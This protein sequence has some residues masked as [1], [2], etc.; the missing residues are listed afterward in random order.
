MEGLG[1]FRYIANGRISPIVIFN[2]DYTG[3]LRIIH[4]SFPA[5]N[6]VKLNIVWSLKIYSALLIIQVSCQNVSK[7]KWRLGMNRKKGYE[8]W[9]C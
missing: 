7:S 5:G 4:L 6:I 9:I 3:W 8:R 1:D 2:C